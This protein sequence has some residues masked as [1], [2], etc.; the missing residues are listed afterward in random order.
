M[1]FGFYIK[2]CIENALILRIIESFFYSFEGWKSVVYYELL[3]QSEIINFGKYCNQL[4]KLKYARKRPN[5]AKPSWWDH[6]NAKPH[7]AMT[8]REKLL[9][10]DWDILLHLLYFQ[11]LFW[12][13]RLLL[14]PV[15][16]KI[17]SMINGDFNF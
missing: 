10:I 13:V 7:V 8:V 4:D 6:D 15:I 16:K 14:V 12:I 1:R 3:S 17:F 9:W 11:I 2:M 5:L